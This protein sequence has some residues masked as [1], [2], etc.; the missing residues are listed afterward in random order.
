LRW[1]ETFAPVDHIL[2]VMPSSRARKYYGEYWSTRG[3]FPVGHKAHGTLLA[4][5]EENIH[6]TDSILDV[7]CGDGSK[8]GHFCQGRSAS[9]Q[10]VDVSEQA[11]A[12]ARKG[13]S[14]HR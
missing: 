1:P 5:L 14:T 10:G 4:M 2:S 12:L 7:G 3:F 9:Y 13:D 6:P 11:V 8:V